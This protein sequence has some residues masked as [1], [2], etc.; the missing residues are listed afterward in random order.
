MKTAILLFTFLL[1]SFLFAQ[2]KKLSA[3]EVSAFYTSEKRAELGI[4]YPIF[5]VYEYSDKEGKHHIVLAEKV[6]QK[7]GKEPA[8]V[9]G[10]H[11]L[12]KGDKA[13]EVWSMKDEKMKDNGVSEEFGMWFWTKYFDIKDIDGDGL[14]DPILIYGTNGM[15]K[16]DD[17]RIKILVYYKGVKYG[18]RHQNGT[19]D[20]ERNT[21]V[22]AGFYKLPAAIQKHVKSVMDQMVV[23]SHAIFP[24]GWE[25][26]MKAKKTAFDEN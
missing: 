15:N 20:N 8:A 17:G 16:Y 24:A 10:F 9:Q 23:K 21:K 18:I 22:D 1:S 19:L 14:V 26:A 25:E 6:N 2:S 13:T 7:G 4:E 12:I 5:R 11:F 3:E